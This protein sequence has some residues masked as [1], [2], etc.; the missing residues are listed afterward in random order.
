MDMTPPTWLGTVVDRNAVLLLPHEQDGR[1]AIV[2]HVRGRV[3]L[4]LLNRDETRSG[5]QV[6]HES[7]R[8]A[9]VDDLG[10]GALHN[11]HARFGRGGEVGRDV[12]LFGSDAERADPTEKL[13]G[14][15]TLDEVAGADEP[16][17][18]L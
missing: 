12:D 5:F 14:D 1:I 10:H 3:L 2:E 17:D 16:G 6:D 18:E 15:L 4:V 11:L 7:G 8:G 13:L 9:C